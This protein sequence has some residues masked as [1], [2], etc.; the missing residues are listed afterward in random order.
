VIG[1]SDSELQCLVN[2][3]SEAAAS[4]DD[5]QYPAESSAD[6]AP[7]VVAKEGSRVRVVTRKLEWL[8][9]VGPST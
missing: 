5:A 8:V 1:E 3:T 4:D 2:F 6:Y 7:L 9:P